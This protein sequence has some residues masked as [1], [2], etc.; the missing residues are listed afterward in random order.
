VRNEGWRALYKGLQANIVK[1]LP[2]AAIQ[3][4]AYDGLK[5]LFG[6]TDN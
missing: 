3:F 4:A 6:V 2:E 5:Y 1:C